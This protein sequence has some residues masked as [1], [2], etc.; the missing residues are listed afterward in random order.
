MLA[1]AQRRDR[2]LGVQR[3]RAEDLDRVDVV[4]G[5]QL[6]EVG[7]ARA[8]LPTPSIRRSSTSGRGSHTATTSHCSCS[9]Y[10]GTFSVAMLP[11]PTIPMRTRSVAISVLSHNG[12]KMR[13]PGPVGAPTVDGCRSPRP[14]APRSAACPQRASYDRELIDAVIDEA[15]SCHVGFAIDGRPVGDP[16]HPRPDRRPSLSPRRGREPHVAFARGGVEACVTITLST[17]SCSP[18]PRSTTR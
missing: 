13:S 18:A 3:R 5:E 8:R 2:V 14:T 15:L 1:R 16:D 17:G 7:V 4:V 11:V 10:P 12:A 9:R 6:V